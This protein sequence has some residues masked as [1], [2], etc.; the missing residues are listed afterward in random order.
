MTSPSHFFIYIQLLVLNLSHYPQS[1]FLI[2]PNTHTE[3]AIFEVFREILQ[4]REFCVRQTC[5]WVAN[6]LNKFL[7][8]EGS[9]PLQWSNKR[10]RNPLASWAGQLYRE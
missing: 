1:N 10:D 4:K 7:G 5:I 9:R 2:I 6:G 8:N 3:N